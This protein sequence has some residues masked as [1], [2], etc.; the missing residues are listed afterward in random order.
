MTFLLSGF[1]LIVR[2]LLV[3]IL[4]YCLIYGRGKK[5]QGGERAEGSCFG[6]N[7]DPRILHY[8]QLEIAFGLSGIV[9][10]ILHV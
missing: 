4:P 3:A 9:D 8:G 7:S 2:M 10:L 5:K 1:L 6:F